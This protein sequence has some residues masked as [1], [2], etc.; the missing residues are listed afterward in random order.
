MAVLNSILRGQLKGRIGNN[1]F[2]HAYD[3]KGRPVT[4]TGTINSSPA[5]P[6]TV[7][8]QEQRARF[9]NAVKFYQHATQNFFK[10]AFQDKKKNET[11]YNA[12]MR[13]NL[14]RSCIM[15]KGLVNSSLVP[16]FG[17]EWL[18]SKGSLNSIPNCRWTSKRFLIDVPNTPDEEFTIATLS[19]ALVQQGLADVGDIFTI[20]SV[21]SD[22]ELSEL[23]G[24]IDNT[25]PPA[26]G[27]WQ[28]VVSYSDNTLVDAMQHIGSNILGLQYDFDNKNYCLAAEDANKHE[29]ICHWACVIRTQK[30]ASG[31]KAS[32]TVLQGNDYVKAIVAAI[33]GSESL[34]NAVVSWGAASSAI[35]QGGV[36]EGQVLV[37]DG[38]DY[39]DVTID[40]VAGLTATPVAIQLT[41]TYRTVVVKGTNL[42]NSQP[43]S[44]NVS[45]AQIQDFEHVSD[46]EISFSLVQG[47]STGTANIKYAG[48][49]I[50]N[51][52]VSNSDSDAS[53]ADA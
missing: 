18:M 30:S 10:F 16:A 17:D 34:T 51:V 7:T 44:D 29:D 27:I 25:L 42:P 13:H 19:L 3:S 41:T 23:T 11:D 4:R 39:S 22:F 50:I 5:N 31:L 47:G 38:N 40:S 9:A 48:K 33:N 14:S 49:T 32:S 45:V 20:V 35:L 15:S 46:T 36:A 43:T 28:F 2:A 6:K 37:A 21:S 24:D 12:F 52:T 8:Q 26:W 1:W 53:E